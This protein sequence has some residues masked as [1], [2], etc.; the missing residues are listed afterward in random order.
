MGF[1]VPVLQFFAVFLFAMVAGSVFGIWR[2]YDPLGY[3]A[4]TFVEMHQGAVRGLNTLLPGFALASIVLTAA[5]TWLARAKRAAPLLYLSAILL[6]VAGGVITRL[7]NQPMNA[8]VMNWTANSLPANWTE[9]RVSW[10][11]WHLLRT[12]LSV[13]GFAVLLAAVI[14]DRPRE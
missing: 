10:W 13:C 11:N 5:L 7:F 2:G 3:A 12:G 1:V 8:E 6:M 9:L 4:T 14:V